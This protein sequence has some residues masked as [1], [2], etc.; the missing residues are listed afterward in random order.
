M[1]T[2]ESKAKQKKNATGEVQVPRTLQVLKRRVLDHCYRD[3]AI[4]V[5]EK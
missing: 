4:Y 3:H 5:F 2:K 1:G